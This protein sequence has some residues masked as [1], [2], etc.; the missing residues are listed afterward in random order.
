VKRYIRIG[1][2]TVAVMLSE[3]ARDAKV[4]AKAETAADACSIV[5][6]LNAMEKTQ[7]FIGQKTKEAYG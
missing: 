1:E 4:I 7:E 3:R 5:A 6:A 2:T